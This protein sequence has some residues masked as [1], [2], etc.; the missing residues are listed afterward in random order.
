MIP[1][2]F[3]FKRDGFSYF[4]L[5]RVS[6]EIYKQDSMHIWNVLMVWSLDPVFFSL[7]IWIQQEK[8]NN[9]ENR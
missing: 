2:W 1:L 5:Y 6:L 4:R 8:K 9:I 3:E 7:F